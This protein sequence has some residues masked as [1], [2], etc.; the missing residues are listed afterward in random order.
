VPPAVLHVTPYLAPAWAYG[1]VPGAVWDLACAQA[2]AGTTVT[3]LTTDVR[4]PHERLPVGESHLDGVRIV[5]VRNVSGLLRSWLHVSTPLAIGRHTRELFA[6]G[7]PDIVHFHELTPIENWRVAACTPVGVPLVVSTHG[8]IACGGPVWLARVQE[9]LSRAVLRR[10]NHIVVESEEEI[11]ALTDVWARQRL[12]LDLE[13][14]SV[15]PAGTDAASTAIAR[16][17][18]RLV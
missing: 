16:V 10:V 5:R 17:Y 9:R 11:R 8:A 14:V 15:I 7:A 6:A 1:T 18:A 13:R 12:T 2:R 4:A 3:V